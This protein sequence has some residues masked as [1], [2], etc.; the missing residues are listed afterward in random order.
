[1]GSTEDVDY[2]PYTTNLAMAIV[3]IINEVVIGCN[4]A[5]QPR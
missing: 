2:I 1:M 3:Y 5:G 4:L